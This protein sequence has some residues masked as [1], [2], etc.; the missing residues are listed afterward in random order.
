MNLKQN[1]KWK[2][3]AEKMFQFNVEIN[4]GEESCTVD[5][6]LIN[7]EGQLLCYGFD[8]PVVSITGKDIF[9]FL[10]KDKESKGELSLMT[11]M[12]KFFNY[13]NNPLVFLASLDKIYFMPS[14]IRQISPF[15]WEYVEQPSL[16]FEKIDSK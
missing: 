11:R 15:H 9:D 16:L 8:L 14:G 7:E 6:A 1:S 2:A 10:L 5:Y 13:G 4:N 12:Y 3:D